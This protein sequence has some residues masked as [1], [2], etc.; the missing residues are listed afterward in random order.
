MKESIA[1]TIW[2][3]STTRVRGTSNSACRPSGGHPPALEPA[4]WPASM[5]GHVSLALVL[6]NH[7]P[8]G[9]FIGLAMFKHAEPMVAALER[10]PPSAWGHYTDRCSS[11]SR[12]IGPVSG[13]LR[14]GRASGSRSGRRH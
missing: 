8:V 11:G 14:A 9:N 1:S 10:H 5:A 6:H 3:F 13:R 12:P 4:R 2:Q 7:Q